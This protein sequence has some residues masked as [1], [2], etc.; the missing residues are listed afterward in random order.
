[1]LQYLLFLILRD[2]LGSDEQTIA[3][4]PQN[5]CCSIQAVVSEPLSRLGPMRFTAIANT[6]LLIE[7]PKLEATKR[8]ILVAL[9]AQNELG[10]E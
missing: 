8:A 4:V 2:V 3:V 10:I 1:M 7:P 9:N 6:T 5:L